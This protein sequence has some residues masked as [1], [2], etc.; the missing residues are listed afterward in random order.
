MDFLVRISHAASGRISR[1][2]EYL[3]FS[4]GKII[5]IIPIGGGG[6]KA[7]RKSSFVGDYGGVKRADLVHLGASR[8]RCPLCEKHFLT[9]HPCSALSMGSWLKAVAAALGLQN[10]A[11]AADDTY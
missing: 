4:R 3:I 5:F 10:C 6:S 1:L 11:S 9:D 2:D 7:W 8:G